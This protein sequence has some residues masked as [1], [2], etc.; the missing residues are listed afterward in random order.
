MDD[1]AD[2]W[3]VGEEIRQEDA[4]TRKIGSTDCWQLPCPSSDQWP[5]SSA[6]D[7]FAAE[8]H[9][10]ASTGCDQGIIQTLKTH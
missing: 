4:A 8:H 6:A 7:I 9:K 5:T 3:G 10:R 2:I 1:I